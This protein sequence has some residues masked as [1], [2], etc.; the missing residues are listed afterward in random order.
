LL[1]PRITAQGDGEVSGT[2]VEIGGDVV[3]S[4]TV[5]KRRGAAGFTDDGAGAA[6]L[7]EM[8]EFYESPTAEGGLAGAAEVE[9]ESEI[10]GTLAIPMIQFPISETAT[11]WA[12]HGVAVS[13]SSKVVSKRV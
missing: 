13:F 2:G 6:L 1:H 5:I 9:R 3:L 7:A 12:T 8:H 4:C 10:K 11:H